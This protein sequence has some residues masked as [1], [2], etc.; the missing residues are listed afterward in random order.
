MFGFELNEEEELRLS[1]EIAKHVVQDQSEEARLAGGACV[2][3]GHFAQR[4]EHHLRRRLAGRTANGLSFDCS[5][6]Q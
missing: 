1:D 6:L 5:R 4:G 2:L 3:R